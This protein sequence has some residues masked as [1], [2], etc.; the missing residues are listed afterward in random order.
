VRQGVSVPVQGESAAETEDLR[1]LSWTGRDARW[2]G[3]VMNDDNDK[4]AR[5]K[6]VTGDDRE[7]AWTFIKHEGFDEEDLEALAVLARIAREEGLREGRLREL[8]LIERMT[9]PKTGSAFARM[10]FT[11]SRQRISE[12]RKGEK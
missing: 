8:Y 2:D 11:W 1:L 4:R 5:E 10:L 12:L 3:F 9:Q 6:V 7:I